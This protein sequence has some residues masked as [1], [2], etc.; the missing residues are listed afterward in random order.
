MHVFEQEGCALEV[1]WQLVG[2]H[3]GQLEHM[4]IQGWCLWSSPALLIQQRFT[5]EGAQETLFNSIHPLLAGLPQA[6]KDCKVFVSPP[7]TYFE[8]W[9]IIIGMH[10]V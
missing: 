6:I 10:C 4:S 9:K 1:H 5:A 7:Y 3:A 2:G 8:S